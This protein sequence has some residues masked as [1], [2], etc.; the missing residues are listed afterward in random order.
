MKNNIR[1][2]FIGQGW[3]GRNY[4]DNFE[5]RGFEVI[6]YALEAPYVQNK[7]KIKDCDIVFIAVPTPSTPRGFDASIVEQAFSLIGEGKLAVIKS[8]IVPGT[9]KKFQAAHSHCT[10]FYSPEFLSEATAK[11]DV[12]FPFSNI[13]GIP[14]ET[15]ENRKKAERLL[16]VLPEA[17]FSLVCSSS[18]AEVIKYTHNINGY[19][20]IVMFNMIHDIAAGL[21]CDWE[22]IRSA[23]KADPMMSDRYTQPVH[24]SG[25]GAGGHCF[26]KDMAAFRE[27]YAQSFPTDAAGISVLRSLENKN[28]DLLTKTGKDLDLVRGVYGAQITVPEPML[29]D[30]SRE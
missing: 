23:I 10:I 25:R 30:I 4:A 17:P 8:T 28:V 24:K 13:V 7:E 19:I 18:E 1:I 6:R 27:L 5:A 14:E 16:S 26:I 11:H 2:G 3:I 22:K 15:Q 20:Q 29:Q 21:N 9:T 12:E